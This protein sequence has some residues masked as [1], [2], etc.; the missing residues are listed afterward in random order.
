MIPR[1]TLLCL[2]VASTFACDGLPGR[3]NPDD[4]YQRPEDVK[5]FGALYATNCSGCHGATGQLGPATPV[6][7][8]LY[9]ALAAPE[10]LR[11]IIAGGV[12]GTAMPRFGQEA[13]GTLTP[14]QIA[15]LASGLGARWSSREA[16]KL[17]A[18]AP[19][20]VAPVGGAVPG[21]DGQVERGRRVYGQFCASC[22]GRDGRGGEKA[23]SIVHAA[24]LGLVSDQSLRTTTL[25]GRRDL[26]MPNWHDLGQR[27]MAPGEIG[28]VVAWM[29]SHRA[30]AP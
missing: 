25:V 22:H 21:H 14:E 18:K 24:Y 17:A 2:L 20:L 7:D 10:Y 8:P 12:A 29:A 27:P 15:I 13:G 3:P 9:L 23:G 1:L 19:G 30:P 26:G 16:E 4:R 28:D 11:T 5:D 6:G